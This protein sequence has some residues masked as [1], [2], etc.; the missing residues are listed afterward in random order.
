MRYFSSAF[1]ARARGAA[2]GAY[3][4]LAEQ[5]AA[6]QAETRAALMALKTELAKVAAGVAAVERILKQVE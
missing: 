4:T 1:Q 6:T 2:D 5:S 3:R